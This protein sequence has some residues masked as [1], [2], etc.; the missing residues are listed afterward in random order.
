MGQARKTEYCR[1]NIATFPAILTG[2]FR[3]VGTF[4]I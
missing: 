2:F 3:V 1:Q 4:W